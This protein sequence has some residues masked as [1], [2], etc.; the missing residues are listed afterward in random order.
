MKIN[1]TDIDDDYEFARAKYYNLVDK[2][3][4]ALELMMELARESEH[5]RAFEV[6]SNMM[7]QNAEIADRLMELQKKKKE[8]EKVD[9]NAPALPNSMTQNNVFVGSS[10]DLQRMLA[11]KFEEKANVIESEE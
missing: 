10:S 1:K 11:S 3:D 5:P 2:G 4:E 7:K 6:L 9:I 8:A